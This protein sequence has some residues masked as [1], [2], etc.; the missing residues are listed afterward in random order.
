MTRPPPVGDER[1]RPTDG[2]SI[3]AAAHVGALYGQLYFAPLDALSALS[4]AELVDAVRRADRSVPGTS[5]GPAPAKDGAT[6]AAQFVVSVDPADRFDADLSMREPLELQVWDD[7]SFVVE[8]E[9]VG[10]DVRTHPETAS[11]TRRVLAE[12]GGARGW[13]LLSLVNDRGRS[14]PDVWNASFLLLDSHRSIADAVDFARRATGVAEAHRYGGQFVN[15][16]VALLRAGDADGLVGTPATSVFQPR[17]APRPS[18]EGDFELALDLC[19]FANSPQ[20]GLVVLGLDVTADGRVDGVDA[21]DLVDTVRRVERAATKL[22]F[23]EPEGLIVEAVQHGEGGGV[24]LVVVPAQEHVLKP[25]LVHGSVIDRGLQQQ[26][27]TLVERH[28]ATIYVQGIVALHSQI[29]AG[30]ALLGEVSGHASGGF[31]PEG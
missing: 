13:R 24:V 3:G 18:E 12:W 1:A 17:P 4:A 21:L 23:P 20:G 16:I 28:E 31:S 7:G 25:F 30:R 8:I 27:V 14:L 22:I 6:C 10:E 2:L 9:F 5:L 15:Q 26:G 19:A 29:A 11:S